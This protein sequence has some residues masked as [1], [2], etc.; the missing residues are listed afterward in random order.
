M[1]S[2]KIFFEKVKI[3]RNWYFVEYSPPTESVPFASIDLVI[4]NCTDKSKIAE[5]MESE[6]KFWLAR[7]PVPVMVSAFDGKEN[8]IHL[9][10]VRDCDHLMGCLPNGQPLPKFHWRLLKNDELS[11]EAL[12]RNHL[13]EIYHDI[14]FK[15]RTSEDFERDIREQRRIVRMGWL[16]VFIWAGVVPLAVIILGETSV[17]VSKIVLVYS[18]WKAIVEILK[19]TGKLKKS[20]REIKQALEKSEMEHHHYHCKKNPMGFLRLKNENFEK[21]TE[22]RVRKEAEALRKASV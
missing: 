6:L 19:L 21:E 1:R 18:L 14:P 2:E 20:P 8:L 7:Y 16:I 15:V 17:W 10:S 11:P 22:E 9:N 5:A 4:L 3:H 13:K 12:N